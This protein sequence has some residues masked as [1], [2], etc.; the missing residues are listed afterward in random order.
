M[1]QLIISSFNV[2]LNHQREEISCIR[3]LEWVEE[4]KPDKFDSF[5]KKKYKSCLKGWGTRRFVT[6]EMIN[7]EWGILYDMMEEGS[8]AI[9]NAF[10]ISYVILLFPYKIFIFKYFLKRTNRTFDLTNDIT[11]TFEGILFIMELVWIFDVWRLSTFDE[12][13]I[14][15]DADEGSNKNFMINVIWY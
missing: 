3:F 10:L 6:K 5:E 12:T 4:E 14:W 1:F 2:N 15:S 9:N 7:K 11:L 13:N 8:M